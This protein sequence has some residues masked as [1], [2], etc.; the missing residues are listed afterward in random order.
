EGDAVVALNAA[1]ATDGII[2]RIPAGATPSRPIEIVHLTTGAAATAWFARNAV[3]VGPG[4]SARAVISHHGP[5]GVAHHTNILTDVALGEGASLKLI[6]LQTNGDAAQH[7][8][9]YG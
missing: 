4:A 9:T 2:L 8:A 5:G 1:L 3:V 7:I 6:D